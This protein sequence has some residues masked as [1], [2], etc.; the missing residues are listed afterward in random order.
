M[1]RA[2]SVCNVKGCTQ[3]AP[4]GQGKCETHNTEAKRQ[5]WRNTDAKRP[6]SSARGYDRKWSATRAAYLYGHKTCVQCGAA[7]TDVDHIDGAGPLSPRG[8]DWSNLQAMC[9]RC[10]TAKTNAH[11]GG[12]WQR[13][14]HPYA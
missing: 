4:H 8:H 6:S 2:P 12:G 1:P 11:D 10:H 3:P 9:H 5:A 7:A 14:T 13:T